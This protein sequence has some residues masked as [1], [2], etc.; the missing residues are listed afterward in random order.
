MAK[1]ETPQKTPEMGDPFAPLVDL[2]KAGFGG[3]VSLNAA[4]LESLGDMGAEFMS[5]LAERVKEDVKT[6]HE[7][8]H[9]KDI[10]EAQKIQGDFVQK[11][12]EQYQVE[13]GKLMELGMSAF[14]TEGGKTQ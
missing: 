5:F 9:C 4:W 6:Q 11:A 12:I 10:S 7:I 13:T 3:F 8:L 2:Q 14:K 1:T